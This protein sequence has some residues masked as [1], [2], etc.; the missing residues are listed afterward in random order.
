ML[1]R[2]FAQKNILKNANDHI[3]VCIEENLVN[4]IRNILK[5]DC[6]VIRKNSLFFVLAK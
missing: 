5:L 2:R 1:G 4:I 6:I 3:P